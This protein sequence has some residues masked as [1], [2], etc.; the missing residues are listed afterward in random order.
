[1]GLKKI[2]RC[3]NKVKSKTIPLM[4]GLGLIIFVYILFQ[5]D[6][7]KSR[8]IVSKIDAGILFAAFLLNLPV[9]WLKSYR[10]NILLGWQGHR[11]KT[12]DTFLYYLAGTYLGVITPGRVGEFVKVFYLK[13]AGT[14]T[15]SQGIP[16][17]LAD[18]LHDL[19]LLLMLG[20]LG[21]VVYMPH[22]LFRTFGWAALAGLLVLPPVLFAVKP[23]RRFIYM[24]ADKMIRSRAFS[25]TKLNLTE[26][27]GNFKKLVTIRLWQTFGLTLM[28][29]GLVFF[30]DYLI[31]SAIHIPMTYLEII[32]LM[33]LVETV[34][35]LPVSIA[36]LGTRE[37]VL[38]YIL[39]PLGMEKEMIILYSIG[40]LLIS[41]AGVAIMGAA[42]WW[43]KPVS[44]P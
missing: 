40:I 17:V 41:F 15:I 18:R 43:K 32:P 29:A 31:L 28:T 34:S 20:L 3:W 2:N 10:W 14:A 1:M 38:L 5:I 13:E 6:W 7:E 11:V 4:R 39:L 24:S 36:G 16:G 30:Q 21:A 33:A 12:G 42:A 44:I 8:L 26:F 19:Y 27:K 23:S 9:L 22:A 37:A 25:F 35:L